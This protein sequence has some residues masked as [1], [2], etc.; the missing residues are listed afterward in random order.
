LLNRDR[1]RIE[2]EEVEVTAT[3]DIEGSDSEDD[4]KDESDSEEEE[5]HVG[6]EGYEPDEG[7]DTKDDD[8]S[9]EKEPEPETTPKG[10]SASVFYHYM[11]LTYISR[12]YTKSWQIRRSL[13]KLQHAYCT[14][15]FEN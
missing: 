12:A 7:D 1:P 14:E 15:A 8:E 3:L 11:H 10:R 6:D 4:K 9:T 2:G 13:C 5:H